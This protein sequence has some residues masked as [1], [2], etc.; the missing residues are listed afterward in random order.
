MALFS[1]KPDLPADLH[2]AWWSFLDCA[3]VI[4]GGR[5]VLLG[6]LPTGRVEP[7][8]IGVGLS[9]MRQAITDAREWMPRWRVTG[10]V[11]GRRRGGRGARPRVGQ[12]E[13]VA[14]RG[15]DRLR[16]RR[17]GGGLDPRARGAAHRVPGRD[18]PAR[19]LLRRR[20]GV[21]T[22]LA[23][24]PR[25]RLTEVS[26]TG[27]GAHPADGRPRGYGRRSAGSRPAPDRGS[28][29]GG[30]SRCRPSG[31]VVRRAG[32]DAGRAAPAGRPR[33]DLGSLDLASRDPADLLPVLLR[34]RPVG[35]PR[36][37]VVPRRG[38]RALDGQL[39]DGLG[40]AA[41][42]R[43]RRDR[44]RGA[45]S[46]PAG[47]GATLAVG[48]GLGPS[49]AA[50][51]A[52]GP[53]GAGGRPAPLAE[54]DDR[55]ATSEPGSTGAGV[56]LGPPG[57]ARGPAGTSAG[58]DADVPLD[59]GGVTSADV[60]DDLVTERPGGADLEV[61]P[62]QVAPPADG[63]GSHGSVDA[64]E[65]RPPDGP[66]RSAARGSLRSVGP[67]GAG[68]TPAPPVAVD[69]TRR[70]PAT[71]ARCVGARCVGARCVGARCVGARRAGRRRG[72]ERG[73]GGRHRDARRRG[74]GVVLVDRGGPDGR[75]A[76]S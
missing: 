47:L 38:H 58:P 70:M 10:S 9:S 68:G 41:S 74:R 46:G 27:G 52:P 1:R 59:L 5:R 35:R 43:A 49:A 14:R 17:R 30:S 2:D 4:E 67:P 60:A 19:Q 44:P 34:G 55:P 26:S 39:R 3:E 28:C 7:A 71:G 11:P 73:R 13:R 36:V 37:R 29:G 65:R 24:A 22:D 51:A 21:A 33:S 20:A 25:A 16:A 40:A 45:T 23:P 31:A 32:R 54:L 56:G 8:P 75:R 42:V 63:V 6:T 53:P 15:R 64:P 50:A 48:V 76:R 72:P 66:E 18:R 12:G 69:D 62:P 57:A 61:P